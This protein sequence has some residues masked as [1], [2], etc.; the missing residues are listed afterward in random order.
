MFELFESFK[1]V[2]TFRTLSRLV[3]NKIERSRT[4]RLR[5]LVDSLPVNHQVRCEDETF[6]AACDPFVQRACGSISAVSRA[7]S[8]CAVAD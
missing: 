3:I 5:V 2:R 4:S 6:D 7:L 8:V 1:P